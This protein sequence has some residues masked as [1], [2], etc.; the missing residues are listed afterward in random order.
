MLVRHTPIPA[1]EAK[2]FEA[3]IRASGRDP[4]GFRAQMYEA[5]ATVEGELMRRVH[6]VSACAAAQYDA[7]TG[8][9]WTEHF[10][11]HLARGFF[12]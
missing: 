11:R 7:S 1:V 2:A 10:A 6:I 5:V 9:E 8:R 4:A 3:A 12:G